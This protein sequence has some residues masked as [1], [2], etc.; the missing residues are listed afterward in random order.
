MKTIAYIRRADPPVWQ[1]TL[2]N[3]LPL[4][5]LSS[6]LLPSLPFSAAIGYLISLTFIA[7]IVFLLWLGWYTPELIL[8]SLCPI[9]LLFL[10]E[11]VSPAYKTS[12]ILFC[13]LLL[14][15]GITGY[16]FSLHKDVL[17]WGWLV[18]VVAFIGTWVLAS[19]ADQNYW[20]MIADL[21]YGCDPYSPGCPAPV[22]AHGT[23]WWVLFF[24]S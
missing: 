7:L 8:Y 24:R 6:L 16:R 12:F 18:L 17:G 11:E 14:T 2:A 23:P 13:T 9:I 10:F 15:A 22:P 3:S 5:L 20:Q 4:W 19:N 21:G 1:A